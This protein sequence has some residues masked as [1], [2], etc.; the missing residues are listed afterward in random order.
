MCEYFC[1]EKSCLTLALKKDF[2]FISGFPGFFIIGTIEQNHYK[3]N[4][5]FHFSHFDLPKLYTAILRIIHFIADDKAE[6]LK[7]EILCKQIQD[8]NVNYFISGI[9]KAN[10]KRVTFCLETNVDVFELTLSVHELN[11]FLSLLNDI[12]IACLCL[13]PVEKDLIMNAILQ[14]L[15]QIL[16][17]QDKE[18][19]KKFIVTKCSDFLCTITIDN[20]TIILVNYNYIV[21]ILHK[22]M[23]LVNKELLVENVCETII[24]QS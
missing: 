7:T 19:A 24:N 21:I 10:E 14:P 22:L 23:T 12:V 16:K 18:N 20:L 17:F 11:H 3:K 6:L 15:D 13:K 5:F 2:I 9:L 8:C 4:K 1:L